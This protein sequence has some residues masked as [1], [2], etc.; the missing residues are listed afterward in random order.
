MY[1]FLL[2]LA[3]TITSLCSSL[4]LEN[5]ELVES[6]VLISPIGLGKEIDNYVDEFIV[7]EAKYTHAGTK[8]K[9][10]FDISKYQKFSKKIKYIV[11]EGEPESLVDPFKSNKA[12]NVV[13][14]I[15]AQK[16]I[17]H[18][19]EFILNQLRN[20]DA[21]DW[22]IYSDSDEITNLVNFDL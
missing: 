14:R 11:V 18:Q 15:N 5:S 16:R 7:C 3:R 22:I 20:Y 13:F 8:K 1:I 19:R 4:A 9:L 21:N 12:E 2:S 10:N 6:L 17:H